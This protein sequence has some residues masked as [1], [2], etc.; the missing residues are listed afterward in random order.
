ALLFGLRCERSIA[1]N[2]KYGQAAAQPTETFSMAIYLS[3]IL[4]ALISQ[5]ALIAMGVLADPSQ[6]GMYA[7]AERFALAA[8]LI[9]Q[10]VYL[11]VASRLAAL[12]SRGD[13]EPLR[14]LIR[15]VTRRVAVATM[16]LCL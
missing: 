8:A 12:Y 9:G 3:S 11:A 10:A 14:S 4:A 16:A 13:I 2:P 7:A 1:G 5:L 15:S 6:A